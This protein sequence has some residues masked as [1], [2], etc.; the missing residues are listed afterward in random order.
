[1]LLTRHGSMRVGPGLERGGMTDVGYATAI[2][3]A[4]ML[5]VA[6]AAKVGTPVDTAAT[7]LRLGLPAPRALARAVPVAEL[8]VATALL[9]APRAGG[10]AAT[11]LLAAFTAVLGPSVARGA[12]VPCHCFGTASRAPV[13]T[14]TLLRN[15]LLIAAGVVAA[16]FANEPTV[17]SRAAVVLVSTTALLGAAVVT[18]ADRLRK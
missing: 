5:V 11:V 15:G 14:T 2:L 1:V 16:A 3:L 12:D 18:A 6:A 17:P 13:T 8:S 4:G 7:F 9:A 10:V